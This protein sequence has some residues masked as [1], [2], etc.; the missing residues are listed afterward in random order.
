M[1]PS[2]LTP[3]RTRTFVD[4]LDQAELLARQALP[5]VMHERLS[6]A[7]ALVRGG[8]ALLLSDGSWDVASASRPGQ[9]HHINGVGC[10]CE[11][12]HFRAPQGR[13]KHVLSTLL[14]RKTMKLLQQPTP[15]T[16][17]PAPTPAPMPDAPGTAPVALPE[18]RASV[19]VRVVIQGR[20]CQITLRDHDEQALLGRLEA[21]LQR[22]PAPAKAP[23]AQPASPQEGWCAIHHCAMQLND[24][25]GRTWYSH[26]RPDGDGWCKGRRSR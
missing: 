3:D 15:P 9:T 7:Y 12:A 5:T 6:A 21:L 13:C 24:K 23:Q 19:N 1:A 2:T 25:D 10:D 20:E 16:P 8:Q 17:T 11:D 22:Y 26:R 14:A 4:A 18:A